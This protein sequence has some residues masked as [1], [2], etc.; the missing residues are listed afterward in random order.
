MKSNNLKKSLTLLVLLATANLSV[1]ATPNKV[2]FNVSVEENRAVWS[3]ESQ[4][5]R[6][7]LYLVTVKYGSIAP[8]NCDDG[9]TLY[10]VRDVISYESLYHSPLAWGPSYYQL[11]TLT[12]QGH[13]KDRVVVFAEVN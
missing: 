8:K 13:V 5:P 12:L 10:A 9:K 7:L 2:S 11:C 4:D 3:F 6:P 1:I